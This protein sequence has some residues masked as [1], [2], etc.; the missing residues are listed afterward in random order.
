MHILYYFKIF[1]CEM[2]NYRPMSVLSR[3]ITRMTLSSR[4]KRKLRFLAENTLT[5]CPTPTNLSI[6][7]VYTSLWSLS[8]SSPGYSH[9]LYSWSHFISKSWK[10]WHW[11]F[12]LTSA[13]SILMSSCLLTHFIMPHQFFTSTMESTLS[14]ENHSLEILISPTVPDSSA[15]CLWLLPSNEWME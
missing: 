15:D 7:S 1:L 10:F 4:L 11:L 8:I 6:H 13:Y 9:P 5:S 3:D 14:K 2:I 12:P